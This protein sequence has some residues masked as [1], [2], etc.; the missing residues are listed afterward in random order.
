M[1]LPTLPTR[2]GNT[3]LLNERARNQV[4]NGF[5]IAASLIHKFGAGHGRNGG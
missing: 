5:G 4:R 3:P 2:P 1:Q